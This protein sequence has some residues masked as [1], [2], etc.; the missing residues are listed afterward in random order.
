MLGGQQRGSHGQLS[1]KSGACGGSTLKQTRRSQIRPDGP[2]V[3]D[4]V[5]RK[6]P[7][8]IKKRSPETPLPRTPSPKEWIVHP[9]LTTVNKGNTDLRRQL[10]L[11]LS[12][13]HI[14]EC[15]WALV[16]FT[17]GVTRLLCCLCWNSSSWRDQ[18]SLAVS[19]GWAG[20]RLQGPRS[21]QLET[22]GK[23]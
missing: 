17:T 19:L 6:P 2:K 15:T 3:A 16:N 22:S 1:G 14:S 12:H 21:P 5:H 20:L 9:S 23:I 18:G 8:K 10:C 4:K 13:F 7:D 11:E